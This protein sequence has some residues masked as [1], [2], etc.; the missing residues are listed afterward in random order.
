MSEWYKL[1][2]YHEHKINLKERII[3]ESL[4]GGGEYPVTAP[5]LSALLI[6]LHFKF[7]TNIFLLNLSAWRLI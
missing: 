2:R 6:T 5:D 4:G 3:V 7:A 1:A